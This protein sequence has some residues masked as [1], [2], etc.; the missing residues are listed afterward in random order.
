[1]FKKSKRR[2]VVQALAFAAMAGGSFAAYSQA[3]AFPVRTVKI[4]VTSAVGGGGD[5]MAR[6]IAEKLS[7]MWGQAVVVE[8]RTGANG[9]VGTLAALGAPADG[10]TVFM[11]Y[12]S[13]VQNLH[14]LPTPG[15]KLE[16]FAPVSMVAS[17]PLVLA[18]SSSLPVTSVGDLMKLA[19]AEDGRL[20]FGS[21]GVG[22]SG[23]LM[24]A[25]LARLAGA[26]VIHIPYKGE[27]ASFTDLASGRLAA[28]FGSIGFYA[29]QAAA[30]KV[31]ILAVASQQRLKR[32]PSIPT[33]AEAGFAPANLAG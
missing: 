12:T 13:M 25:T 32:Y 9:M 1:M 31:R 18:A 22:S 11:S 30:G 28:H 27:S 26:K 4:I 29:P 7:A 5:I 23:H 14:V 15:Y 2:V 24:G 3:G 19:K 10:Y 33:L 20:S 8:Q 6:L 17:L 16:D 21:S